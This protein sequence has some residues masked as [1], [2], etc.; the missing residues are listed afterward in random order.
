MDKAYDAVNQN[1]V[2]LTI[3]LDFSKPFDTVDHE[4]LLK[5][6]Y[7]YDFRG[8][9]LD[10][11]RPFLS[12]GSQF[13]ETNQERSFSLDLKICV[14]QGSTKS[15]L[16]FTLYIKNLNSSRAMLKF[17]HFADDTTLYLYINPSNDHTSLMNSK[18][19]Q[20]QT[21][22]NANKLSL[23]VQKTNY[24]IISNRNQTE[25]IKISL[26]GQPIAWT[27]NHNFQGVF[28]NDK[29]KFDIHINKL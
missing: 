13:V 19:A 16:L 17:I 8:K 7:Y 26:S 14:P 25:N 15:P 3:F 6:L 29:L 27:F 10:W 24:M 5:N 23:N 4:T 12:N 18:L 2:L 28:Y 9:I 20:V 21:W 22:I 1:R 11:L